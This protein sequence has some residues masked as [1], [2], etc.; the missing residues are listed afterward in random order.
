MQLTLSAA[1]LRSWSDSP[2]SCDEPD[3][4]G[5][6]ML[7]AKKRSTPDSVEDTSL[8]SEVTIELSH[9]LGERQEVSNGAAA[10]VSRNTAECVI[11]IAEHKH[12]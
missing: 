1:R 10:H 4:I 5:L 11:V 2:Q 7:G 8:S 12:A 9:Q 6:R 3:R